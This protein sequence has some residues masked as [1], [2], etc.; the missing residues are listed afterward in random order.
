[1]D[2]EFSPKPPDPSPDRF[3]T[4]GSGLASRLAP[5]TE[6]NRYIVDRPL[7][8]GTIATIFLAHEK[9]SPDQE[10]VLKVGE[11]HGLGLLRER[12]RPE[13]PKDPQKPTDA[14]LRPGQDFAQL[15]SDSATRRGFQFANRD[16][17]NNLLVDEFRQLD[18]GNDGAPRLVRPRQLF[19]REQHA[20]LAMDYVRGPTLREV[21]SQGKNIHLIWL[22]R[23]AEALIEWQ[24][25]GLSG[26][27]DLKPDNI[28]IHNI[29]GPILIDPASSVK[30]TRQDRSPSGR[31]NEERFTAYTTTVRYNPTLAQEKPVADLHSLGIML[32]E[33]LTRHT[34]FTEK[35]WKF[36]GASEAVSPHS[37]IEQLDRALFLSLPPVRDMNP[38]A[39]EELAEISQ[40]C[41]LEDGSGQYTLELFRDQIAEYIQRNS[42]P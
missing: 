7:A 13:S 35:P 39:S 25:H 24:Q 1:M 34:P 26:H 18:A 38:Y 16:D 21:L 6:I 29:H 31:R 32:Y 19:S 10:V 11:E 2:P 5:G 40:R 3:S 41:V 22:Q 20:V 42:Q 15:C 23:I 17:V 30:M 8:R 12:G 33:F 14:L 9:D 36:A 37:E 28:I 4:G 27:G